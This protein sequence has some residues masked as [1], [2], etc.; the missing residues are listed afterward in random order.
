MK[1]KIIL[2]TLVFSMFCVCGCSNGS[3]NKDSNLDKELDDMED[4]VSIADSSVISNDKDVSDTKEISKE[5]SKSSEKKSSA[6]EEMNILLEYKKN[7]PQE[8][9]LTYTEKIY[10]SSDEKNARL[11]FVDAV[12]R[13]LNNDGHYEM[14]VKYVGCSQV[15][16]GKID[17][18]EYGN[19]IY[20]IVTVKNGKAVET[21]H[22]LN[23]EGWYNNGEQKH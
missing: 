4:V 3:K 20:D 7:I 17:N 1:I 6:I 13:D 5:T 15:I 21:E 22:Y 9:A 11:Y 14:V 19:F 10:N 18:I 23:E 8:R 16:N 12:I 2:F